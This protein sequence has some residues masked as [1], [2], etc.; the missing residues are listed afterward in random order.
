MLRNT[1]MHKHTSTNTPT[2]SQAN[3]HTHDPPG[4]HGLSMACEGYPLAA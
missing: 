4:E 1:D 3:K 2:V